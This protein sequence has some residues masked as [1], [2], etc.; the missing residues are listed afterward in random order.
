MVSDDFQPERVGKETEMKKLDGVEI[1]VAPEKK[2]G[3]FYFSTGEKMAVK[4]GLRSNREVNKA[5]QRLINH[6]RFLAKNSDKNVV[7]P[8]NL[9]SQ[10]RNRVVEL[11][12]KNFVF[13]FYLRVGADVISEQCL[14]E[15]ANP[16]W[17]YGPLWTSDAEKESY[18]V[19]ELNGS[20]A[21][22]SVCGAFLNA[23]ETDCDPILF[24]LDHPFDDKYPNGKISQVSAA[25]EFLAES[26]DGLELFQTDHRDVMSMFIMDKNDQLSPD[27]VILAQGWM[28]IPLGRR[29]VVGDSVVGNVYSNGG[30]LRL[31]RSS[32]QANSNV[33]VGF[34]AGL[35]D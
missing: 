31:N 6:A 24:L 19:E 12:G 8:S 16:A 28:R 5:I 35:T 29:S 26:I 34:S 27:N 11:N 10:I 2:L 4:T 25:S 21:G 9:E 20:D 22:I 23:E 3:E 32:G 17:V 14:R 30:Q 33:G 7:L 15:L 18:T 13:R 1:T